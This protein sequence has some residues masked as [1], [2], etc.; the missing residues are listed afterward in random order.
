MR[1]K[2][3]KLQ[4]G[5]GAVSENFAALTGVEAIDLIIER[6]LKSIDS[7]AYAGQ[8]QELAEGAGIMKLRLRVHGAYNGH[9]P[10]DRLTS[11]AFSAAAFNAIMVFSSGENV[12]GRFLVQSYTRN[13]VAKGEEI[14]SAVLE[15]SGVINGMA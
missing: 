5:D 7:P 1:G 15:N 4:I 9:M 12:T 14:F 6:Q 3:V 13:A 2:L 11:C 10:D 8:W